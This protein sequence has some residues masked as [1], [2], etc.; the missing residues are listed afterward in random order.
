MRS[1]TRRFVRHQANWYRQTDPTIRWFKPA[2]GYEEDV[3]EWVRGEVT[4]DSV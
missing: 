3:I 4:R 1:A 2:A